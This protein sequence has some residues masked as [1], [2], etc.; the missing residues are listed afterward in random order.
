MSTLE[1]KQTERIVDLYIGR[2]NSR[3]RYEGDDRNSADNQ[4]AC[5]RNIDEPNSAFR[6]CLPKGIDEMRVLDAGRASL[7]ESIDGVVRG[8]VKHPTEVGAYYETSTVKTVVTMYGH[9][10]FSASYIGYEVVYKQFCWNLFRNGAELHIVDIGW[11]NF[12]RIR[13]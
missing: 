3:Y 1:A 7:L 5:P 8:E 12:V 4:M 2:H 6:V 13:F 10:S 11:V 9:D